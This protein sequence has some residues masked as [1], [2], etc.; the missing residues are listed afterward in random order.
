M[1]FRKSIFWLHLAAGLVAG[2]VI[3]VMSLTGAA[4]A[5][6]KEVIAWAERDVQRV[7][8]PAQPERLPVAALLAAAQVSHPEAKPT[9]V[10]I[11]RDPAA[12]V[13][14]GLGRSGNL[15]ANPYT[16]EIQTPHPTFWR[17]FMGTMVSW[18]R[19]LALSGDQQRMGKAVT[20]AC[21]AAFLVLGVTGLYLW[22]P[23]TWS[24]RALKGIATVRLGLS[25]KARDWN[26]HNA[27][28]LW[29][30]LPIIVLT[31]TALPISYGWAG[32][33]I[34]KLN[35][36]TPAPAAPPAVV[37]TP[38]AGAVALPTEALLK[39]V[40]REVPD[41]KQVTLNLG[42]APAGPGAPAAAAAPRP[43]TGPAPVSFSVREASSW[44]RT[45][46]TTLALDPFTGAVLKHDTF[47]ALPLGNQVR[48]W[49]RYLH[50]GE[51]LGPIGQGVAGIASLVGAL[52]MW[53]GFA[54]SW[55]R[56]FG[57]KR[58]EPAAT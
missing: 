31:A 46:T 44:P 52:L 24:T 50:T 20:G 6:E 49:T 48:G 13:A 42:G 40:Y 3:L 39:N 15:Y 29:F 4:L 37:A 17:S 34:A 1:T 32:Q 27:F 19:Y 21:N 35:P 30:A 11:K 26:W 51:A 25:G 8:V 28:G 54:L 57:G 7:T 23:R 16:G 38:A 41:W 10:V 18:H 53:T 5:Y 47:D 55:R 56:F 33:L 58:A 45:A 12:A 36:S 9:A 22:W 14:I 43:T 2:L